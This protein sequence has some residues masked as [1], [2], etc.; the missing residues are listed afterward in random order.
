MISFLH[1]LRTLARAILEE[2]AFYGKDSSLP[3]FRAIAVYRFGVWH[4]SLRSGFARKILFFLYRTMYRYV[5]NHY[6]IEIYYT[7]KVGKRVTIAHQGGIVIHPDAEIG[8]FCMIRQNVTIGAV[9]SSR[10]WQAPK[11]GIGVQVGCGAAIL[12]NV[13][14]GERSRIGPNVVVI[15]NV[16]ANASVFLPPPRIV[17]PPSSDDSPATPEREASLAVRQPAKRA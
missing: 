10:S 14:I 7:T 11:L 1:E 4:Q 12:G 6:G 15:T 13:T 17:R 5:R 16:P 3:G 9:S 2:W 8:D